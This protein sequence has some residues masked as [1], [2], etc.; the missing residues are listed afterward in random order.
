MYNTDVAIW[1]DRPV[2]SSSLVIPDTQG[3]S[4]YTSN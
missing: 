3:Y 4:R 2:N 1:N